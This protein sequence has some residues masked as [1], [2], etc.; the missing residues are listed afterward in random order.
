MVAVPEVPVYDPG[1]YQLEVT[2]PVQGGVSGISNQPSKNLANRTAY[3]KQRLDAL[4]AGTIIPPTV[5]PLNGAAFTGSTT[6]PNVRPGDDSTLIANTDFVQTAKSGIAVVPVG[7]NVNVT[8]TQDQW[9][10]GIIVF[11]GVITGPV[12]VLFPKKSGAWIVANSTTGTGPTGVPWSLTLTTAAGA[13]SIALPQAPSYC[14]AVWCDGTAMQYQ[15]SPYQ[16]NL[17]NPLVVAA[18]GYTPVQQG[19]G[20]NQTNDKI[21]LGYDLGSGAVPHLRWQIGATDGGDLVNKVD[22][23]LQLGD[24]NNYL[25]HKDPSGFIM[26]CWQG[27]SVTG[28]DTVTFPIAFPNRCVQVLAGEGA[29]SGWTA[30]PGSPFV[31]IFGTQNV[32]SNSFVLY[33]ARSQGT[34]WVLSGGIA[35][36]YI[37]LGF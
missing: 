29:P 1:V 23:N 32:S 21:Y 18:L 20:F 24:N 2:D 4:I 10:V 17:T 26:Q 7:G 28:L 35:Y 33:V 37:A 16:L 3:L 15:I 8:L 6:A 5:A 34:S 9:G 30:T 19:G 25:Y 36:R 12:A 11:T 31:T 14:N 13:A 22:F 27:A